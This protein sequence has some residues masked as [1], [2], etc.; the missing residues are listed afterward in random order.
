M[1]CT[2][3]DWI[4]DYNGSIGHIKAVSENGTPTVCK[5]SPPPHCA[6][7]VFIRDEDKANAH[8]IAAAPKLYEALEGLLQ[9]YDDITLNNPDLESPI[10]WDPA[11][12]ALKKAKGAIEDERR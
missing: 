9:W 4:V 5:Y 11:I 2:K 12:K 3:G 6:S 8:L 10:F 1:D 7:S